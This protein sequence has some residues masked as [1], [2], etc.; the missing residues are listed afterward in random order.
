GVDAF[1]LKYRL[2]YTNPA[3]RER[4]TTLP[5]VA[6]APTTNN[7]QAYQD[8]RAMGGADGQQAVKLLRESASEYGFKPD[9][10]GIMG[11]SAGGAVGLRAVKGPAETRPNF[12]AAIYAAEANGD[13]PPPGA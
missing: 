12:A 6:A 8:I 4:G 7:A 11:F 2:R 13:N 1:V 9:R 5:A 10:I 3:G